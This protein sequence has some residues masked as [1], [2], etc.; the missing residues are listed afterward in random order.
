[1][2]I[3]MFRSMQ[4]KFTMTL[5]WLTL[6]ALPT[7]S[8]MPLELVRKF[9]FTCRPKLSEIISRMTWFTATHGKILKK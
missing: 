2:G 3:D 5:T 6:T 1:M 8:G 7:S 4:E 9:P